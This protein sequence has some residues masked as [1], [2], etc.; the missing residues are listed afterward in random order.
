MSNR[1]ETIVEYGVNEIMPGGAG[2]NP[3]DANFDTQ[4]QADQA[5][6]D[7]LVDNPE[8][9]EIVVFR[10]TIV[11]NTITEDNTLLTIYRS[12]LSNEL[13]ANAPRA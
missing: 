1:H 13:I 3:F 4:E 5:G 2:H 7:Y 10:L 12:D 9:P 6:R 11:D 8:V